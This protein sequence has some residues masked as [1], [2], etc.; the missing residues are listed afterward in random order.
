MNKLIETFLSRRGYN[1]T[2]LSD[3]EYSEHPDL[4]DIDALCNRLHIAHQLTEHVVILP[5][6]DMDGI[7]SGTLGYAGLSEL[8]FRVSLFRPDPSDG[9]G[10]TADTI[11]RLVKEFPDVRI[12]LTCDV[13]ITCYEGVERA[14]E[15][16]ITVLV[17][18][19]HM[20]E[21][22]VVHPASIVVDPCRVDETYPT[23]GICGAH[24][25][26]QVLDKYARTYTDDKM[27]S[28]IERL[29]VFAGIGTISDLMP[30]VH[31]NREL[32]RDS[33]RICR[34]VWCHGNTFFVDNMRGCMQYV[35]AFKGLFYAL[36]AFAKN[37]KIKSDADIDEEF[38]G[39]YFAPMFNSAKR[40]NGDMDTVFGV[41]FGNDPEEDIEK[42]YKMNEERKEAVSVYYDELE[43]TAQPY[44]PYIYLSDAPAGLLGLLASSVERE[45]GLPALVLHQ[46]GNKYTGSGRSP[47]WYPAIDR[48]R[49]E[50]FYIAG[51]QGAFGVG[52]T[53]T[54]ELKSLAAYMGKDVPEVRTAYKVDMLAKGIDVD[55][56]AQADI[57]LCVGDE[58]GFDS[59]IDIPLFAE[60]AELLPTYGPFGKG[61]EA[62]TVSF[63]FAPKD[64]EWKTLGK[65]GQHV[66]IILPYGF[67]VLIWN[68]ADKM[69]QYRS[70]KS[71][72]CIGDL[73]IN[74]FMG[75]RT[76]QFI[77]DSVAEGV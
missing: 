28:Q 34:L 2:Y 31:E 51:H 40:M 57:R 52:V 48:I 42:L 59:G 10:F 61:F 44:A 17:T 24:V 36:D 63:D 75:R 56:P 7:A 73:G 26:W 65:M 9:Y 68:A 37:D 29:R 58:D 35:R 41:F 8:G 21:E 12:I 32:V 19:H 70:M 71:L 20:Q 23:K 13:G 53:D 14:Q 60:Y 69:S 64:G 3:L 6:F 27:I 77:V 38:F 67:E 1:K 72:H 50:G 33:C 45:T 47:E 22:N 76:V 16:G 15:Y 30:L 5:D 39:Y 74:E 54:R 18:D 11:D 25:L 62:P 4:M 43:T 66:K 55:A 46:D 49:G